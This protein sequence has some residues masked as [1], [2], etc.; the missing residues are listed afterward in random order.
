MT[1]EVP[2]SPKNYFLTWRYLLFWVSSLLSNI[3]SWMQQIAQPWLVLSLS[4]SSFWVGM[5]GFATN[6]PGLLF[7][8]PG[9]VL[10]D[11]FDRKNVTLF[12]Q[13][14]QFLFVIAMVVLLI[15]GLLKIW[16]IVVISFMVG[17]TDALC[18]PSLQ[19]IVPALVARK[20]IPR[21]VSLNSTQ[22]NL[23]RILGPV[24]AGIVIARFGSVACFSANAVSYFPYFI[25]IWF[26]Y[27]RKKAETRKKPAQAE[28]IDQFHQI[29]ELLRVRSVRLPLITVFAAN[30]FCGPLITFCPVLI[31]NI[32]H[33]GVGD[34]GWAMTAFGG[35]ALIGAGVS[36]ISLP[37]SFGRNRL[38][39]ATAIAQGF[40]L[41]AIAV[42]HSFLLLGVLLV[43]AGATQIATNISIN[44][45]LQ[46]N[47][48]DN[49]R[50]KVAS[51]YQLAMYSG[52]AIGALLTGFIVSQF[53]I[54]DA[55]LLNGGLAVVVQ[56]WLLW[57]LLT[58]PLRKIVAGKEK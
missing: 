52:V 37:A 53:S 34:F 14:I 57:R 25:A 6:I 21:A 2:Q 36:F 4:G 51:L 20:D 55:F 9:G 58:E 41:M 15:T 35:G 29:S 26:I 1:P 17:L 18:N 7:T 24:I 30:F 43:F 3:G 13:G 48:A 19:T 22:Y 12:F 47:A 44:S 39:T 23:S 28:P 42:N 46:E 56:V 11:R 33:S 8:L 49:N 27:P 32:F 10:A 31:K 50:G 45:F 54:A 40:L 38:V 5:T 16:M